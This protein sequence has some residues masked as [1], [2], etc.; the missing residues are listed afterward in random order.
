MIGGR[1]RDIVQVK[2][3]ERF[4]GNISNRPHLAHVPPPLG[5]KRTFVGVLVRISSVA[6]E[7]KQT[8]N[9][10]RIID[11]AESIF[12]V[13]RRPSEDPTSDLTHRDFTQTSK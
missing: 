6:W 2:M 5:L 4:L 7:G 9:R 12:L 8:M 13:F 3:V 10:A 11:S 1:I